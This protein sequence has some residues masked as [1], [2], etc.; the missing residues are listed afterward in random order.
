[1]PPDDG[2][3]A[4]LCA[5]ATAASNENML[6]CVPEIAATVRCQASLATDGTGPRQATLVV[7]VHEAVLHAMPE[8][9]AEKLNS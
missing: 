6:S 8:T 2:K 7:E 4:E 5:E 3:L 9:E 1:M